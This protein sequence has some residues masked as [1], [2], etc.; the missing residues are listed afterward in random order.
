MNY[1]DVNILQDCW[2]EW[3]SVIC[4]FGRVSILLISCHFLRN[5]VHFLSLHVYVCAYILVYNYRN[6]YITLAFIK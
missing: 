1:Q 6:H 2:Y 3:L 4:I 5:T